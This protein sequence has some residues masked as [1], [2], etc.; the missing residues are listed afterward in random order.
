MCRPGNSEN[1]N[2]TN[3]SSND[4]FRFSRQLILDP[5]G[6]NN[7]FQFVCPSLPEVAQSYPELP[8]SRGDFCYLLWFDAIWYIFELFQ[9]VCIFYYF[10]RKCMKVNVFCVC[11]F[12]SAIWVVIYIF[13]SNFVF[14]FAMCSVILKG[15]V[16]ISVYFVFVAI[17]AVAQERM[18]EC[19][20]IQVILS[21]SCESEHTS[22]CKWQW[23]RPSFKITQHTYIPYYIV[24]FKRSFLPSCSCLPSRF[25]DVGVV[26][27]C[28]ICFDAGFRRNRFCWIL[29]PEFVFFSGWWCLGLDLVVCGTPLLIVFGIWDWIWRFANG[30]YMKLSWASGVWQ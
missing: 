16:C 1:K 12:F 2:V 13:L 15:I 10:Q 8:E 3:T 24:F 18:C 25:I 20:D 11:I 30:T 29:V 9:L 26:E 14:V 21:T 6:A 7:T 22:S 4:W 17:W 19:W 23:V 27:C 28:S 5:R